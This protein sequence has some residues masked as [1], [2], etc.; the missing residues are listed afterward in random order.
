MSWR[1]LETIKFWLHLT[2][3]FYLES[4]FVFFNKKIAY[5]LK[6]TGQILMV[7]VS[8]VSLFYDSLLARICISQTDGELGESTQICSRLRNSFII[9]ILSPGIKDPGG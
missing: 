1:G 8:H 7:L 5:I 2:L 3:T 6:T 9:I 4:V